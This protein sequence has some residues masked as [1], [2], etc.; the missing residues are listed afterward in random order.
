MKYDKRENFVRILTVCAFTDGS[1]YW[2]NQE[3]T[4]VRYT[5]GTKKCTQHIGVNPREKIT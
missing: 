3:G 5:W 4:Y 2:G 1:N